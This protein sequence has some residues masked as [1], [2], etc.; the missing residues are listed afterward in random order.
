MRSVLRLAGTLAL[1]VLVSGASAADELSEA[2]SRIDALDSGVFATEMLNFLHSTAIN[3]Y[4]DSTAEALHG[5]NLPPEMVQALFDRADTPQ[6]LRAELL[7]FL[8]DTMER[9]GPPEDGR[10]LFDA[11]FEIIGAKD[12]GWL[13]R[14]RDCKHQGS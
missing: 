1:F 9:L 13:I 10:A 4:V 12:D 6:L 11:Q 2:K 8:M 14:Q 7:E 5:D 3:C